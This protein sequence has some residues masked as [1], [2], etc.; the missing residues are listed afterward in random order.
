[1]GPRRFVPPGASARSATFVQ[2]RRENGRWVI[3][4]FGNEVSEGPRVLGREANAVVRELGG[5]PVPGA[6][7][8]YAAGMEFYEIHLPIRAEG[9]WLTKYGLPRPIAPNEL[10]RLGFVHGV[11]AYAEMGSRTTPPEVV[12]LA[13]SPGTYQ[14]YQNMA[15]SGC[16]P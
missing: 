14:P 7:G 15:G 5:P 13:V 9:A 16:R 11:A 8:P 1:M 6:E 3:D 12:Y 2:W 10:R 4:S